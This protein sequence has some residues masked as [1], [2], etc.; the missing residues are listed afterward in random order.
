LQP[1]FFIHQ[2]SINLSTLNY[3]LYKVELSF[4]TILFES[5]YFEI[6]ESIND[7]V[8]IEYLHKSFYQNVLFETGIK[9]GIRVPGT[10]HTMLPKSKDAIYEDQPLNQKMISSR[11]YRLFKFVIGGSYGV[12]M[13]VADKLNRI[14]GCSTISIDGKYFTKNEGAAFEPKEEENYPLKGYTLDIRESFARDSIYNSSSVNSQGKII[15]IGNIEAKAFGDN[16]S[17]NQS[18][19]QLT[20]VE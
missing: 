16:Y 20:N 5:D 1:N 4:D 12:P 8:Y 6:V 14:F 19:I 7:S 3:G 10:I 11:P 18:Y 17:P 9:M 2:T 13:W 15:I